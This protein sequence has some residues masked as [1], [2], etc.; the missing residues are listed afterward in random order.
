MLQLSDLDIKNGLLITNEQLDK[1]DLQWLS[2]Q[3]N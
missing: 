1:D 3:Y 2:E